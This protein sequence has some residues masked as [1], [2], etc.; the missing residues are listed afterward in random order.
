MKI[1]IYSIV[2]PSADDFDKLIKISIEL[3]KMLNSFLTKVRSVEF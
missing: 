1:N 3:A 2:K